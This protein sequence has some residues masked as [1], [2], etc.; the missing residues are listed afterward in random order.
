MSGGMPKECV[1]AVKNIMGSQ[2]PMLQKMG[3]LTA[4][5]LKHNFAWH[6]NI[7]PSSVLV[8]PTNRAGQMLSVEDVWSKGQR[9]LALG[10]AATEQQALGCHG[11]WPACP[12]TRLRAVSLAGQL[13]QHRLLSCSGSWVPAGLRFSGWCAPEIP[14][15]SAGGV[16]LAGDIQL[17]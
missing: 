5:L 1:G 13:S 17:G 11:A 4:F 7:R 8:H 14:W 9:M 6:Q 15:H 16:E 2:Q 10:V 12:S 3:E